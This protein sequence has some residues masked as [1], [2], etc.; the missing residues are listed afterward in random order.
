MHGNEVFTP[1]EVERIYQM[2][3]ENY[4]IKK[5]EILDGN[6]GYLQMNKFVHPHFAGESMRAAMAFLAH[7]QALIIDLRANGGDEGLIGQFLCSYFFSA[8][9]AEHIQLNGLYDR[10]QDLVRQY[11]VFPYVPECKSQHYSGENP[12]IILVNKTFRIACSPG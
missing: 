6:I 8:F 2:K 3:R 4:G 5:V 11:W 12:T 9:E 1:E 7:T 10:R